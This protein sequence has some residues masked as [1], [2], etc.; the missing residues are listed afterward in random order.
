MECVHHHAA[1]IERIF[2]GLGRK[3]AGLA[4]L[5]AG[6]WSLP[7]RLSA[8]RGESRGSSPASENRFPELDIGDAR[9]GFDRRRRPGSM[10]D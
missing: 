1:A 9:D 5:R 6:D 8:T 3:G 4:A 2:P 7:K 10:G